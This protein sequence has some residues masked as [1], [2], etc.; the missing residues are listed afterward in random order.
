MQLKRL[1]KKLIQN[2]LFHEKI[3]THIYNIY[4]KVGREGPHLITQIFV[5]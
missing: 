4:F 3:D 1:P 2:S 5:C